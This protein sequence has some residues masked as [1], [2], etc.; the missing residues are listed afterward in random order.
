MAPKRRAVVT[1]VTNEQIKRYKAAQGVVDD[2]AEELTCPITTELPVDP[3]TAE[4]GR[5]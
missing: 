3:V 5:V 1:P 4:D 2:A